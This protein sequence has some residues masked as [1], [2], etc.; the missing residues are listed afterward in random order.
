MAQE[1]QVAPNQKQGTCDSADDTQFCEALMT[2]LLPTTVRRAWVTVILR[3]PDGADW[4]F[5]QI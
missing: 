1:Q 4:D 3:I 2:V 5:H